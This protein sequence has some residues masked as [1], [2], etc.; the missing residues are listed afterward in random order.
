M[1]ILFNKV[2]RANPQDRTA[3]SKWYASLKVINQVSEKEVAK[4][5]S[6]ETT[7]NRKEVEMALDQFQ[8]ILGRLLLDSHSVQLGDWG[9]FHLTCASEGADTAEKLTAKEIKELKIRFL[10]GKELKRALE[11]ATFIAAETVL[12]KQQ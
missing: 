7:L 1:S 4:L 5:V 12:A 10:P 6:D 2:E 11:D 9:S 8:K 3:P